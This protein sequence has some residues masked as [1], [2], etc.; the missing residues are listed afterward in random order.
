M[1]SYEA[2]RTLS[3]KM[4]SIWPKDPVFLSNLGTYYFVAAKDNKTAWKY[5]NKALKSDSSYYP[6]ISN[7]IL[8][9]RRSGNLKSERKY[10]KM[11]VEHGPEN[12]SKSA[13]IRLSAL[14]KKK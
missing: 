8:M 6:A 7:C 14:E 3:E 13:R 9:A 1:S 11:M 2:F 5:Y 4:N 12:E 10:L